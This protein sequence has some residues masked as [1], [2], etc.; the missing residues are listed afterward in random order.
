MEAKILYRN[1][2]W[3]V[4]GTLFDTYPAITR[5]VLAG[6]HDLGRD[7]EFDIVSRLA[8]ISLQHCSK[9]LAENHHIDFDRLEQAVDFHFAKMQAVDCPPFAGVLEVCKYIHTIGGKNVIVTHRSRRGTDELLVVHNLA[10]YFSG[11]ITRDDGYARKPDPAAFEAAL[12]AY[13][14][15]R[16]VTLTVGDREIDIQAGQAAG[17]FSCYYGSKANCPEADLVIKSYAELFEFLEKQ[18]WKF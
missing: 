14:L 13:Q 10:G 15:T 11:C 8:K 5:A 7:E 12:S 2:I 3:D 18:T 9:M 6:L 1:I 16:E 17:M 4:D